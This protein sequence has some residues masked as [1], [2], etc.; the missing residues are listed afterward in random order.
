MPIGHRVYFLGLECTAQTISLIVESYYEILFLIYDENI[1]LWIYQ[2]LT[3]ITIIN[4]Y[5][6]SKISC[7][8]FEKIY[9]PQFKLLVLKKKLIYSIKMIIK[10]LDLTF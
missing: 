9:F 3:L 5:K 4:N 7:Y 1:L 2:I 8:K 6:S 10:L